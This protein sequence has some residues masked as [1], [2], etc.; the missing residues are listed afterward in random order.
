M[1]DYTPW[2][3]PWYYRLPMRDEDDEHKVKMKERAF[4]EYYRDDQA[5]W[6]AE[7]RRMGDIHLA[8]ATSKIEERNIHVH[9][10]RLRA[11]MAERRLDEVLSPPPPPPSYP[12]PDFLYP[13]DSQVITPLDSQ[14]IAE[15][16]EPDSEPH[17]ADHIQPATGGIPIQPATGGTSMTAIQPATGGASQHAP[18]PPPSPGSQ[19][20]LQA[21][22][23]SHVWRRSI[24]RKGG[25]TQIDLDDSD[26]NSVD[27][28]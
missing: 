24:K 6:L 26:S 25:D 10:Y 3:Y 11:K 5:A 2:I 8:M 13:Y 16:A 27:F 9:F 12:E 28:G 1:S 17:A 19:P 15:L 7:W 14:M 21:A 23:G 18:T 4:E 20:V 22:S